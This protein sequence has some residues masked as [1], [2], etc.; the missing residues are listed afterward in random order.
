MSTYAVSS[1]RADTNTVYENETA[2][3]GITY[4]FFHVSQI[5]LSRSFFNYFKN[6]SFHRLQTE[7]SLEYG[8]ISL[9]NNLRAYDKGGVFNGIVIL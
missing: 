2:E 9:Q 8:Y 6:T 3:N 7:R 1:R 5:I 4:S